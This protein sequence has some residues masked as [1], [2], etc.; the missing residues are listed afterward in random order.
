M[1]ETSNI[2]GHFCDKDG[3]FYIDV[4]S[5]KPFENDIVLNVVDKYFHPAKI[6]THF[7]SRDA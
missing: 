6:R 1:I 3:N 4:F 2:T 7:I 5:C